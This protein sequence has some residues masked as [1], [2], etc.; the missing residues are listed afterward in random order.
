MIGD[1]D[2]SSSDETEHSD[3]VKSV[4]KKQIPRP[5][6]EELQQANE[7]L[8]SL[9]SGNIRVWLKSHLKQ[10]NLD[11]AVPL[12]AKQVVDTFSRVSPKEDKAILHNLLHVICAFT[13]A[14][15]RVDFLEPQTANLV[16][17]LTIKIKESAKTRAASKVSQSSTQIRSTH[18]SPSNAQNK[19]VI[20]PDAYR[21]GLTDLRNAS[22]LLKP[23]KNGNTRS[24]NPTKPCQ[25]CIL[26]SVTIM[27]PLPFI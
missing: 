26:V 7:V 23:S 9:L 4:V 15:E 20:F 5:S 8:E 22:K 6:Q 18:M 10:K 11:V 19:G 12:L 2:E 27:I 1:D 17:L 21:Y 13:R 16:E 25:L 24:T 14:D 3:E